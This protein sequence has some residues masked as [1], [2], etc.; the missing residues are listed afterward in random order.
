MNDVSNV[1]GD[2][3]TSFQGANQLPQ[4]QNSQQSQLTRPTEK[5]LT[6]LPWG[7]VKEKPNINSQLSQLVQL[8]A[9]N[10]QTTLNSIGMEK[11]KPGEYLMKLIV[12]NFAQIGSKKLEQIVNG[13]KKVKIFRTCKYF[14][15][16]YLL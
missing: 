7:A 5:C 11:K 12:F 1:S 14:N 8:M 10:G 6:R 13:E 9:A 16:F 2:N 4:Q 3:A 15:H